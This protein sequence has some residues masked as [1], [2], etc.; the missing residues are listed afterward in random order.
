MDVKA[1]LLNVP[2]FGPGARALRWGY[3]VGCLAGLPGLPS[4]SPHLARNSFEAARPE[5]QFAKKQEGEAQ[6]QAVQEEQL[7]IY[8]LAAL[9]KFWMRGHR[10]TSSWM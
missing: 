5:H 10:S 3:H 4:P 6:E 8:M 7:S 9:N 2:V 1:E